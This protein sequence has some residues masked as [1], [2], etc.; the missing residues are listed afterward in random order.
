MRFEIW[1]DKGTKN[2]RKIAECDFRLIADR[3]IATMPHPE[4]C[5]I[6]LKETGKEI[7]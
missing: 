1:L 6:I 4:K 7:P 5:D 3:I 2:E